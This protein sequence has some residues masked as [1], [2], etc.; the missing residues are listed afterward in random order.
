MQVLFGTAGRQVNSHNKKSS[1]ISVRETEGL[2][3]G[4]TTCLGLAT[5]PDTVSTDNERLCSLGC[6][7]VTNNTSSPNHGFIEL[8]DS[9][10]L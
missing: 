4:R 2:Y 1:F 8:S 3:E 10:W 5:S 7:L 6:L 9:Q